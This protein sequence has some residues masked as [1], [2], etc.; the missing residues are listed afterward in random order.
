MV[1]FFKFMLRLSHRCT[2]GNRGRHRHVD[3]R[4][5][6]LIV[7]RDEN[8]EPGRRPRTQQNSRFCPRRV[9]TSRGKVEGHQPKGRVVWKV[10]DFSGRVGFRKS[11]ETGDLC[12][13]FPKGAC[14][15]SQEHQKKMG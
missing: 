13:G 3:G 5:Q 4:K 12:R 11:G 8:A 14:G 1:C 15:R 7:Y 9:G 2:I 10:W 6:I